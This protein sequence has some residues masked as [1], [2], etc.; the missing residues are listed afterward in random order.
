[1]MNDQELR[2]LLE[3]QEEL[4]KLNQRINEFIVKH[5]A[6]SQ[7]L[8]VNNASDC[9]RKKLVT[10]YLLKLGIP[11]NQIGFKYLNE[12][13]NIIL[14]KKT[15]TKLYVTTILYPE[16]AEQCNSTSQSVERS[17]RQTI[18][19]TYKNNNANNVILNEI[20]RNSQKTYPTNSEF[21]A[22]VAEKIRLEN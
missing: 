22:F 5:A 11:S 9:N 19:W 1:M 12:A 6:R 13:I 21:L 8:Q 2:E 17:I 14:N 20:I 10:Y 18:R 16:V 7:T 15:N 4:K 3:M